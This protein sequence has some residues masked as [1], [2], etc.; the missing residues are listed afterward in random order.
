MKLGRTLTGR[1]IRLLCA[2]I[3][4]ALLV[5]GGVQIALSYSDLKRRT[6]DLLRAESGAASS[7]VREFLDRIVSELD[8]VNDFDQPGTNLDAAGLRAEAHRVLRKERAVLGLRYFDRL[9]CERFNI[10]RFDEDLTSQCG[11]GEARSAA[12]PEIVTLA[13]REKGPVYGDVTFPDSSEPRVEVALAGRGAAPGVLLAQIE[14]K[15]IHD[16][17]AGIRF[18]MAGFAY[19]VDMKGRLL[20][21]PDQTLVLRNTSLAGLPQVSRLLE[22]QPDRGDREQA[23]I[24]EDMSGRQVVSEA[25]AIRTPGWWVIVE[26][27]TREAF[28]PVYAALWTTVGVIVTVILLAFGASILLARALARPIL[29]LRDGAQRL[30]AGDLDARIIVATGDELEIL[31]NEFNGMA[32]ALGQSYSSLEAKV[33][34]RTHELAQAGEQLG[35]LNRQLSEQ[36]LE[37]RLRRDEAER[38]NAAKTRFLAVA[39][40]DLRQP[41][42][43]IGLLVELL[44]ERIVYPQVRQLVTTVR[45]SVQTMERLFSSLLDISKLDA[46]A[47]QPNIGDF[48]I[49]DLLRLLEVEYQP[50]ARERGLRL[51]IV[52]CRA[53]VRSDVLLLS[54]ILRNL[55]SNAL[56]YTERGKV[57]VGCRRKDR[58]LR[59]CVADTGV[60]IPPELHDTVF[61]EFYQVPGHGPGRQEG[62]GL[63][64]SIVKRGADL[65]GHAITLRSMP[66]RGTMFVIEVPIVARPTRER[67]ADTGDSSTID[68]L[69]GSFVLVVDDDG[70]NRFA[71]CEILQQWGC[72]VLGTA[73]AGDA[74]AQLEGHLRTPD[75]VLCDYRLGAGEDGCAAIAEIRMAAGIRVPAILVTGDIAMQMPQ[76]QDA[77]HLVVLHK[78]LHPRRLYA[79]ACALLMSATQCA[80]IEDSGPPVGDEG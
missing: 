27:P 31:A 26:E 9:G 78:P 16:T 13:R 40:H 74:L 14:L 46:G 4:L 48:E 25:A 17:V 29:A 66:G 2:L 28:A 71:T 3:A 61:D 5:A 73:S 34:A 63:G 67:V 43:A 52:P 75:L 33:T 49:Q 64:L 53:V 6:F 70:D 21:H 35:A 37:T 32:A 68:R 55:V 19:V 80:A 42:H 30:G 62:L 39:S 72:L 65:L 50:L 15:H 11:D 79:A 56:R 58:M 44:S 20:A 1:Y 36:L 8:W 45:A 18:G 22:S 12:V 54:R 24:G 77:G 38:A 10:S 7:S 60:G 57:L 47:I 51:Q 41:M 69:A 23:S 59:I 76:E